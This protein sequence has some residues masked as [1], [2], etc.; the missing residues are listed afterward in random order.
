MISGLVKNVRKLTETQR[1][2]TELEQLM[3]EIEVTRL[4]KKA[5]EEKIEILEEYLGLM[6]KHYKDQQQKT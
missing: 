1:Q 2:Y 3:H 4:M 6:E 5:Q